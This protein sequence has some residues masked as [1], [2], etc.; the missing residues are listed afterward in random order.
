MNCHIT[1]MKI[2]SSSFNYNE[3]IISDVIINIDHYSHLQIIQIS[4][5]ILH[6]IRFTYGIFN[7]FKRDKFSLYLT[8]SLVVFL[9]RLKKK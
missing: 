1:L 8:K 6:T 2:L 3:Q 4:L 9:R 5:I 7:L